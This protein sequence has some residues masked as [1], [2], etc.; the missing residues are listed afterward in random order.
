MSC[1]LI[2]TA[3]LQGRYFDLCFPPGR[4]ET[5]KMLKMAKVTALRKRAELRFTS[6]V[7]LAP[8][9]VLLILKHLSVLIACQTL[10]YALFSSIPPSCS[11]FKITQSKQCLMVQWLGLTGAFTAQGRFSL[12]EL[13]AHMVLQ[14]NE[15]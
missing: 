9:S 1:H 13:E 15:K 6:E 8:K 11:V 5:R 10:C 7:S 3:A 2:L 4:N 12:L 14:P